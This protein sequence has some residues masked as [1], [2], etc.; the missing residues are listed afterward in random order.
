MSKFRLWSEGSGSAGSA[1]STTDLTVVSPCFT[2][3]V[4][5][6]EVRTMW[7]GFDGQATEKRAIQVHMLAG[8][9]R[10]G[11][12]ESELV[13]PR[14]GWRSCKDGE[15]ARMDNITLKVRMRRGER[16][17]VAQRH[18]LEECTMCPLRCLVC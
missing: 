6:C 4:L 10:C 12:D 13:R 3:K 9:R 5:Y 14:G 16:N 11:K 18:R 8:Q 2:R 17:N 1:P 15:M 7:E